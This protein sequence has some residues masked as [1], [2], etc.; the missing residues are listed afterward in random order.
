GTLYLR[1]GR[2]APR[3]PGRARP[4]RAGARHRD[5]GPRRGVPRARPALPRLP[6]LRRGSAGAAARAVAW[7]GASGPPGWDARVARRP[8]ADLAPPLLELRGIPPLPD[9]DGVSLVPLLRDPPAP[10]ARTTVFAE[11]PSSYTSGTVDLVAARTGTL[12][13]IGRDGPA[14]QCFDLAADP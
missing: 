14:A 1:S 4:R 8:L 13:C 2:R 12:K 7:A 3:R 11:A 9:I 6:A 10:F 5:R